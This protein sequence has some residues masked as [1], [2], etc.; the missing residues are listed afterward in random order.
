MRTLLILQVKPSTHPVQVLVWKKN[1]NL[2]PV[3]LMDDI[4]QNREDQVMAEAQPL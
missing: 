3:D 1:L 4:V 2:P